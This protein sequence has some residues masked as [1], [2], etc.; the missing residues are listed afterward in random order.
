MLM[1]SLW[2]ASFF[3][4]FAGKLTFY[5]LFFCTIATCNFTDKVAFSVTL[6]T[7]CESEINVLFGL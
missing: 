1:Q 6:R 5:S 3:Y 7:L 2:M 4:T